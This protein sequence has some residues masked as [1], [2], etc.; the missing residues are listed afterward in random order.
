MKGL[1]QVSSKVETSSTFYLTLT[2]L[3]NNLKNVNYCLTLQ[4]TGTYESSCFFPLVLLKSELKGKIS[5]CE[6]SQNERQ[7]EVRRHLHI[8]QMYDKYELLRNVESDK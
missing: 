8:F 5:Y 1:F 3:N 7:M 4:F 6:R 2:D